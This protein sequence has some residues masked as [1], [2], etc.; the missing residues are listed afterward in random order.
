MNLRDRFLSLVRA[1]G[2]SAGS[3]ERWWRELE[4]RHSEPHRHYHTLAHI[5]QMLEALPHA[6]ETVLAAVWFHD[7][8]YGGM[9]NEERSAELARQALEELQFATEDIALVERLILAT[10]KHDARDLPLEG[11]RFLDADL[12]ILGSERERYR[13]YVE[14]VRQEYAPVPETIFREIRNRLLRRFLDRPRIF[15]TDEFYV[16]FE[17]KARANIEWELE[18]G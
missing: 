14:D 12:S 17:A 8:I 16:R 7:A 3:A 2:A 11:Q 6:S 9:Q 15:V 18:K 1:H 13:Q 4:R 10:K 5:E